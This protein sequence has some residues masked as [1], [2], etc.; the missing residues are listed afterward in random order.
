MPG[1]SGRRSGRHFVRD[2]TCTCLDTIGSCASVGIRQ[3]S[4][5]DN[6][7]LGQQEGFAWPGFFMKAC[8]IPLDQKLDVVSEYLEVRTTRATVSKKIDYKSKN[9]H[10]SPKLNEK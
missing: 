1:K 8:Y 7:I 3:G 9:G 4:R 6:L 10:F 5:N 2:I